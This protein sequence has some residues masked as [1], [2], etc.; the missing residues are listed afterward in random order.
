MGQS[1]STP[2]SMKTLVLAVVITTFMG[3]QVSSRPSPPSKPKDNSIEGTLDILEGTIGDDLRNIFNNMDEALLEEIGY[4]LG[5]EYAASLKIDN[6]DI[7]GEDTASR[8]L[9]SLT[10]RSPILS[11]LAPV[12]VP[13][14]ILGSALLGGITCSNPITCPAIP[15]VILKAFVSGA[16]AVG[17]QVQGSEGMGR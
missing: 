13:L 11:P 4:K 14:A 2:S 8:L 1:E 3:L 9:H 16:L 10:K 15:A 5:Q 6:P 7:S 12:K 17:R